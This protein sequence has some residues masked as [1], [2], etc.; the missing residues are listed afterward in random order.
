MVSFNEILELLKFLCKQIPEV[1]VWHNFM[2]FF[3][4]LHRD[5]M[6]GGRLF[7][8]LISQFFPASRALTQWWSR[9]RWRNSSARRSPRT[10]LYPRCPHTALPQ[11]PVTPLQHL[12][13]T[14][15]F[16]Q[17]PTKVR[18][19]LPFWPHKIP[20]PTSVTRPPVFSLPRLCST[21][22]LSF[23][24]WFQGPTPNFWALWWCLLLAQNLAPPPMLQPPRQQLPQ[25]TWVRIY[26][27]PSNQLH[28]LSVLTC[29]NRP[30]HPTSCQARCSRLTVSRSPWVGILCCSIA[31]S[32]MFSLSLQT[33]SNLYLWVSEW[34][35]SHHLYL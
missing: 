29:T 25:P 18:S 10:P 20:S 5:I 23:R 22:V 24:Q 19:S 27:A 32:W 21:Q 35:S 3:F 34:G 30:S 14:S 4:C 7:I 17:Q 9:S 15:L 31:R 6:K 26:S 28:Q 8:K 33:W 16:P 13:R 12:C 2:S 11:L 1:S